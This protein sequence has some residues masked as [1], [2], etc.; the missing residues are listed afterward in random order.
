[1]V[2]NNSVTSFAPEFTFLWINITSNLRG[3]VHIQTLC[4]NLSK[5]CCI[6]K[7]LRDDFKFQYTEEHTFCQVIDVTALPPLSGT[8]TQ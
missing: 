4:L 6:I 8:A 1:V 3:T 5:V 7:S 2:F